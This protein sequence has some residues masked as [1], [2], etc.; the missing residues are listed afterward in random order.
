MQLVVRLEILNGAWQ[1]TYMGMHSLNIQQD[2][3]TCFWPSHTLPIW[4]HVW[5]LRRTAVVDLSWSTSLH[6]IFSE[7]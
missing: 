5:T 7:V 4:C 2:K 3:K 1:P 6:K